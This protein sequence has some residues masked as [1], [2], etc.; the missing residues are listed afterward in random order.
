MENI[1]NNLNKHKQIQQIDLCSLVTLNS[2]S[3][4][5]NMLVNHSRNAS[6]FYPFR[7]GETFTN[8]EFLVIQ[9]DNTIVI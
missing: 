5:Y 2:Y 4:T 1:N 6:I 9:Q 7:D 8:P 3:M